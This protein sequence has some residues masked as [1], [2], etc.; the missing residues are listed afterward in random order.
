VG[1]DEGEVGRKRGRG[2]FE[3]MQLLLLEMRRRKKGIIINDCHL[4]P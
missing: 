1:E 2:Y 4:D 3:G